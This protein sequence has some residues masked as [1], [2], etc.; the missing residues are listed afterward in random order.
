MPK[1]KSPL[2]KEIR[3]SFKNMD[4]RTLK[5]GTIE[6]SMLRIPSNPRTEAQQAQRLKYGQ[7]VEGW[8]GLSEEAKGEYNERATPLKI[9]GWNLYMKEFEVALEYENFLEWTEQDTLNRLSQTEDRSTF[10]DLNRND[11][12]IYLYKDYGVDHFEDFEFDLDIKCTAIQV[13]GTQVWRAGLIVVT[14]YL[15]SI[16]VLESENRDFL[17]LCLTTNGIPNQF[18]LNMLERYGSANYQYPS[19]ALNTGEVYY[20]TYKREGLNYT[21]KIYSDSA[22]TNLLDTLSLT[23]HEAIKSR[24]L[25]CPTSVYYAGSYTSSGYVEKLDLKE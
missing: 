9:S 22:R 14:N 15:G 18:L 7:A 24:Y 19:I 12:N 10:T 20:V 3:G 8:R 17:W 16:K 4:I 25:M 11:Y 23:L 6:I 13:S 5:D 2:F 1:A 21:C